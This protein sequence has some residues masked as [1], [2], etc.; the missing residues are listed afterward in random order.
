MLL[1][2]HIKSGNLYH[3]LYTGKLESDGSFQVIYL[4]VFPEKYTEKEIPWIRP[5]AEFDEKFRFV[6]PKNMSIYFENMEAIGLGR[7]KPKRHLEVLDA[8]GVIHGGM[9]KTSF[10]RYMCLYCTDWSCANCKNG[11]VE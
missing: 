6:A 5:E 9:G 4:P 1:Y 8:H 10:A 7:P 2:Q 3:R 11:D